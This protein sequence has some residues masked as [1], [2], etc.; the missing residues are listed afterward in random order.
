MVCEPISAYVK[1]SF[2]IL[3]IRLLCD[4]RLVF[5]ANSFGDSNPIWITPGAAL[6]AMDLPD[7]FCSS[8]NFLL[9]SPHRSPLF[10]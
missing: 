7:N 2:G 3:F 1:T 4:P 5:I 6:I 9:P 10:M 8:M